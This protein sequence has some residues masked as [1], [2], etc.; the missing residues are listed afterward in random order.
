[1][2]RGG[3]YSFLKAYAQKESVRFHMP[4]HKGGRGFA[5]APFREFGRYDVSEIPGADNLLMP[6]GIIAQAQGEAAAFFGAAHTF[7][8]TCGATAGILGMLL[9]LRA[10]TRVLAA[11]DCHK[12]V[13]SGLILSGLEAVL[14]DPPYDERVGR[15]TVLGAGDIAEALEAHPDLGAVL[16]TR[17]DYFGRCC[18]VEAIAGLCRERGVLLLVDEAHGA[19]FAFSGEL[20]SSAT[21]Y[22][23][24]WVQSAHKTL[25]APNQA[26]YLHVANQALMQ[27]AA[28]G[29]ALVHTTSPSYAVLAALDEAWRGDVCGKWNVHME[30]LRSWR[31]SLP[32]SWQAAVSGWG[33]DAHVEDTD[34]TRLVI[35]LSR[36]GVSVNGYEAEKKLL[37]ANIVAE[38]ATE[39]AVVCITTPYD[40]DEWYEALKA[41]LLS[42]PAD[43]R[44]RWKSAPPFVPKRQRA[45][46]MRNA[47]MAVCERV[48][49]EL[50]AGR[51]CAC[52]AGLYPP[53]SAL[54]TPGEIISQ[55]LVAYMG[56]RIV[57]GAQPFGWPPHCVK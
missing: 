43:G 20:P 47:A 57:Q 28:L 37:Q 16:L 52:S 7:F 46:D 35:D 42:L 48:L 50:A 23:D 1:M 54:I 25:A 55:E 27:R 5:D 4:G 11:R 14:I 18:D 40:P 30:R 39:Q 10:G 13:L 22:A 19:H 12:S 8:I 15:T 29:L 53:G 34:P 38:M 45:M 56:E 6:E 41:A 31:A 51:V 49:P 24:M 26:A 9:A 33:G 44:I 36:A 32:D 21:G 2:D 3:I 17:P